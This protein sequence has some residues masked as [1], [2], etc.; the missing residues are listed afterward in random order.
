MF[1]I[2]LVCCLCLADYDLDSGWLGIRVFATTR[3]KVEKLLEKPVEQNGAEVWYEDSDFRFRMLYS[4]GPC[5]RP[6]TIAGGFNVARDFVL[7]YEV[8]PKTL[9]KLSDV[10]FKK[11][12]YVRY[13]DTH[14]LGYVY[15]YN[16][17]LGIRVVTESL[18]HKGQEVVVAI[19][20]ERTLK[21]SIEF[22]CSK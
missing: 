8:R 3:A 15:Y 17:E 9:L 16:D 22:G 6:D 18:S 4:N 21:Q 13:V 2:I 1:L 11:E 14:Q 10:R 7:E 19:F 20:F 5:T 12:S